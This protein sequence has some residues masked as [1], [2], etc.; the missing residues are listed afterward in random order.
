MANASRIVTKTAQALNNRII[1][2]PPAAWQ[3]LLAHPPPPSLIRDAPKRT[4]EDLSPTQ[5]NAQAASS[6]RRRKPG[7]EYKAR[8]KPQPIVWDED[9]I[10]ER[11]LADHPWE[12]HRPITVTESDELSSIVPKGDGKELASWSRNPSIYLH[13]FL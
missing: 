13:V 9:A 6:T 8:L 4:S 11:L 7:R 12:R 1:K 10:V 5:R 3:A 2:S